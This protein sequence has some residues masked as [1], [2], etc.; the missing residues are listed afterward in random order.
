[1]VVLKHHFSPVLLV[2]LRAALLV[3]YVLVCVSRLECV[4][5]VVLHVPVHQVMGQATVASV[6]HRNGGCFTC[7]LRGLLTPSTL[8]SGRALEYIPVRAE[9]RALSNPRTVYIDGHVLGD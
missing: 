4:M 5:P 6:S 7:A 2:A 9:L 8:S 3:A 1:M